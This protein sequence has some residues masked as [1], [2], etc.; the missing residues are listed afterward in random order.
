MKGHTLI[1]LT[2]VNTGK[3]EKVEDNNM[4]TNALNYYLASAGMMDNSNS[5]AYAQVRNYPLWQSLLGGIL[6]F[7]RNIEESSET[8]VPPCDAIM[9]ANGAYKYSN[10]SEV[11]EL[12]SFNETESG[13]QDDGSLKLVWDFTTSQAIG[14]INCACL[15]SAAGGYLGCG[16]VKSNKRLG[17]GNINGYSFNAMLSGIPYSSAYL[18]HP[19]GYSYRNVLFADYSENVIYYVDNNSLFY[20]ASTASEHFTSTGKIKINKY[21]IG[22]SK[23]DIK[24]DCN[25]G[26]QL[27]ETYEINVPTEVIS[28]IGTINN[29]FVAE[30]IIDDDFNIFITIDKAGGS[31][32]PN[33]DFYIMKIVDFTNII[34]F[35]VTNT[36]SDALQVVY[37]NSRINNILNGFLYCKPTKRSNYMYKINLN[38]STDIT[39]ITFKDETIT[40]GNHDSM[41]LI[42][43]R[44]YT[45][46]NSFGIVIENN[47][48]PVNGSYENISYTNCKVKNNPLLYTEIDSP[49]DRLIIRRNCLYLAT[50]NNLPAPVVKTASQTMKVTY[51]ITF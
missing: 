44:L 14:T 9:V 32:S 41:A 51:T 27:I 25:I 35:H 28:W 21:R 20:T 10:N 15:T 7:D 38:N 1:Q 13:I 3:I 33:G 22:L 39:K 19:A 50:I 34:C 26:E 36:S 48:Y 4:I 29:N 2:D 40:T 47:I 42:G 17:T 31:I 16:N 23:I 12:G 5:L 30:V 45:S 46:C 8:V 6:L 49:N 37:Y 11:T 24:E 43:G 18:I